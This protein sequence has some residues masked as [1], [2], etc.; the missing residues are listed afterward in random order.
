MNIV[1]QR[2]PSERP[3]DDTIDPKSH[4]KEA[5]TGPIKYIVDLLVDDKEA[6]K[7]LK[8]GKNPS[9]EL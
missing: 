5:T 1:D 9:D 4:D 6:S 7:V 8:L 2:P 3:L